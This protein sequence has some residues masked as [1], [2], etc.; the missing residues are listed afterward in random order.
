MS[1]L[2]L[3]N[4]KFSYNK[5][6]V[7]NDVNLNVEQ[8]R[9]NVI[10]GLNGSGKTTL[11]K[12]ICDFI[13]PQNGVIYIDSKDINEYTKNQLSKKLSY[14]S[15]LNKTNNDFLVLDFL[16][17]GLVNRLK[18]YNSPSIDDIE[19]VKKI[20]CEL[21]ISYLLDKHMNCISGGEKQIV[22]I[23]SAIIQNTEMILLDEPLSALDIKNQNIIIKF[24]KKISECKTIIMTTHNPNV[25]LYLDANVIL[26]KDGR[27]IASGNANE[28]I[29]PEILKDI[30]G[31]NL[32]YVRDTCY[33][34]VTFK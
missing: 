12:L 19:N 6:L 32:V 8:N 34:E 15:Q 29:K 14:V 21:G 16:L 22:H 24:L 25:C 28:I 18:F 27:I 26:L 2:C 31:E 5:N 9:V 20:A 3:E 7:L 30:Y 23:C 33:D 11:L 1:D 17:F 13:K 4:I 10:L